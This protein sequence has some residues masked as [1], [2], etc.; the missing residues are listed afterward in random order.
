MVAQTKLILSNQGGERHIVLAQKEFQIKCINTTLPYESATPKPIPKRCGSYKH[1][2][3]ASLSSN[4]GNLRPH[5]HGNTDNASV[6]NRSVCKPRTAL[7][8]SRLRRS[9]EL[10]SCES[11]RRLHGATNQN[12]DLS[13]GKTTMGKRRTASNNTRDHERPLR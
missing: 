9:A 4:R 7:N 6:C 5:R 2:R 12:K 10:Y 11:A 1:K 13:R 8:I 3:R